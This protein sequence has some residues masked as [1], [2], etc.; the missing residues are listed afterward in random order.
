MKKQDFGAAFHPPISLLGSP[1]RLKEI[2]LG[3]KLVKSVH[4]LLPPGSA[5]AGVLP[6]LL[7]PGLC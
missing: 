1:D 5:A 2:R 4:D 7:H 6:R 3:L